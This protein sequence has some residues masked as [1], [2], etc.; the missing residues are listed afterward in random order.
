MELVTQYSYD[1]KP[2]STV[3]VSVYYDDNVITYRYADG[4]ANSVIDAN[5][6]CE[7]LKARNYDKLFHANRVVLD[8]LNGRLGGQNE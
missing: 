6:L 2:G 1:Q 5:D 7:R 3:D 4:T 8:F